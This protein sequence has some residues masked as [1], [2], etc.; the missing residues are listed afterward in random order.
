MS[1]NF[2]QILAAIEHM[3]I[4][5]VDSSCTFCSM[6]ENMAF[7]DSLLKIFDSSCNLRA[8]D[9]ILSFFPARSCSVDM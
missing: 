9:E 3:L 2:L 1:I 6:S 8:Y 7:N 5:F 4:E